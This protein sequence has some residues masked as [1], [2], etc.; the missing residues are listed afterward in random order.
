M[1]IELVEVNI[2]LVIDKLVSYNLRKLPIEDQSFNM[3]RNNKKYILNY[4][5][6]CKKDKLSTILNTW[7]ST[8][9]ADYDRLSQINIGNDNYIKSTYMLID[10]LLFIF[11]QILKS[12]LIQY[13][14]YLKD[15]LNNINYDKSDINR[16]VKYS[17]RYIIKNNEYIKLEVYEK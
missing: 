4:T 15:I 14:F 13:R 5:M 12:K 17:E 9:I 8:I 16:L 1:K 11:S 2:N 6:T 7:V 3:V 10:Q